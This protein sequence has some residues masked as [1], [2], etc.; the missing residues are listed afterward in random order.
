M[1]DSVVTRLQI[2]RGS[3]I[4]ETTLVHRGVKDGYWSCVDYED[5]MNKT[6]YEY[7]GGMNGQVN[8]RRPK[9]ELAEHLSDSTLSGRFKRENMPNEP[10]ED[11]HG[12]CRTNNNRLQRVDCTG[13]EPRIANKRG[14]SAGIEDRWWTG[15]QT[16]NGWPGTAEGKINTAQGMA[17]DLVSNLDSEE[18][19][20][21]AGI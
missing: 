20:A 17:G 18:K 16:N 6:V 9:K 3:K 19:S 4:S 10:R 13:D 15:K 14:D 12:S 8:E 1:D 5:D 7:H 2:K 11:V 21:V